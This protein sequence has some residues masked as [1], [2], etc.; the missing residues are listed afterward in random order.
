MSSP[1]LKLHPKKPMKGTRGISWGPL[2]TLGPRAVPE[3]PN[4]QSAPG[5]SSAFAFNVLSL[6]ANVF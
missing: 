3:F 4:G 6:Y 1:T 5:C 2:L